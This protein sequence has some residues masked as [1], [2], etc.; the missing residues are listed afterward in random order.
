LLGVALCACASGTGPGA[1]EPKPMSAEKGAAACRDYARKLCHHLGGTSDACRSVLSV[2]VLL[3]G[4]ACSA[5]LD[6]WDTTVTRIAEL[7]EACQ[8]VAAH[9]C[10]ELGDASESCQAIREDLP[11]IPPGHCMALYNDRDRLTSALR[12]REAIKA[13]L[14][15]EQW[16]ALVGGTAPG[17]GSA[18][19]RVVIV[20][21]SDFECP[22]CAQAAETV[23]R[24]RQ[25]YGD[26]VRLVFRQFP[27]PFHPNARGAAL[28]SLAAHEQGKFWEFH[29]LLFKNQDALGAQALKDHAKAAGLDVAAFESASQAPATADRVAEDMR[30]GQS[31]HVQGTPTMFVNGQRVP[32]AVDFEVVAGVIDAAL[33]EP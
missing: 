14:S 32:N 27:L 5:G 30:L 28:A 12:D 20:T 16:Q 22:F 33:Q 25:Q 13:G 19:A 26:R 7:R 10:S 29:D 1:S 21:F 4:E 3:P 9:V 15:E 2:A 8:Q 24:I 6:R 23:H 11:D 31:V 17:F 18:G